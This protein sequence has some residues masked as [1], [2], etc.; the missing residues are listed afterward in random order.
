VHEQKNRV[1]LAS[2]S[3]SYIALYAGFSPVGF[4]GGHDDTRLRRAL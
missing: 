3:S 1:T 2:V 4:H